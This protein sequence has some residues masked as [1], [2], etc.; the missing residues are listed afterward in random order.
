MYIG[1]QITFNFM[2]TNKIK[3]S[4]HIGCLQLY[5]NK[6][7]N[8]SV[9]IYRNKIYTCGRDI[10]CTIPIQGN[11]YISSTHFKFWCTQFDSTYDPIVYVQDTSL[12]GTMYANEKRQII[13][14]IRNKEILIVKNG[15][16]LFFPH[17][18]HL[19]DLEGDSVIM[20]KFFIEKKKISNKEND[21]EHQR[22]LEVIKQ[23]NIEGNRWVFDNTFFGSGSFGVVCGCLDMHNQ[24]K[25]TVCKIIKDT[26]MPVDKVNEK[27]FILAYK[28]KFAKPPL[29]Y[30]RVKNEKNI[31]QN[32]NHP[33]VVKFIGHYATK[34]TYGDELDN[35][36]VFWK[37]DY[38]I[39]QEQ[40]F[41]GDL[42]SY[43]LDSKTLKLRSLPEAESLLIIYQI[44]QAL[45]YLHSQN[46]AHRDLKLDNVLLETPEKLSRIM[47]TDF[48]IAK[49]TPLRM[50]TCIGTPE[51]CA[52]EV[53][54]FH[55]NTMRDI[56]RNKLNNK[57][58]E[59]AVHFGYNKK[60]DIWSLGIIFYYLLTGKAFFEKK[61]D[62]GVMSGFDDYTLDDLQNWIYGKVLKC[63]K[64]LSISH[65]CIQFLNHLLTIN[66]QNRHDILDCFKDRYIQGHKKSLDNIYRGILKSSRYNESVIPSGNKAKKR[67]IT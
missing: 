10:E 2:M 30:S 47:L 4:N 1:I 32:L 28:K 26:I 16:Y 3:Q 63:K 45:K 50:K 60:C 21:E 49:Q 38:L 67:K 19:W 56:I 37:S 33:N 52:P 23:E 44:M 65:E 35:G 24:K 51:Y 22:L 29:L 11:Q 6:K 34:T 53:G 15:T 43:L 59:E 25:L 62:Q 9:K 31:M 41:G 54:D 12:N 17:E 36:D 46:L 58:N 64:K 39:F 42:F 57:E 8:R 20:F 27:D 7:L 18:A 13:T 66:E 5:E 48:G 14:K 40:A 61:Y 55:K